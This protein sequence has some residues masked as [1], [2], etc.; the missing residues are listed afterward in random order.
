MP[1]KPVEFLMKPDDARSFRRRARSFRLA[2]W[3]A[4]R[5]SRHPRNLLDRIALRLLDFALAPTDPARDYMRDEIVDA[6]IG[7]SVA[8]LEEHQRGKGRP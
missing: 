8:E 2:M 5:A 7:F 4:A 1:D 3:L 6:D